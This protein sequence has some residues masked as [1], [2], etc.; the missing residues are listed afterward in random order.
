MV[1]IGKEKT[2]D[3]V[4][5][6]YDKNSQKI[7]GDLLNLIKNICAKPTANIICNG[8]NECFLPKIGTGQECS[9]SSSLFIYHTGDPS[10][11]K[12]TDFKTIKV[13]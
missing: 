12:K 7:I 11:C 2:F 5:N 8:K 9:L 13:Y 10:Q 6:I 1:S 4:Q 3:K